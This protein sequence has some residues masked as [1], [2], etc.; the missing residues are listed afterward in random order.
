MFIDR[1]QFYFILLSAFTIFITNHYTLCFYSSSC[2][3]IRSMKFPFLVFA[4]NIKDG[5][6]RERQRDRREDKTGGRMK[7]QQNDNNSNNN[8]IR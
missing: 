2:S 7:I 3:Y 8:V 4:F 6:W 5:K 1:E